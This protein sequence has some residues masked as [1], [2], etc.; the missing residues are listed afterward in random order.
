MPLGI[1]AEGTP[2][3]AGCPPVNL[4]T[5]VGIRTDLA[6]NGQA[7]SEGLNMNAL[8][9]RFPGTGHPGRPLAGGSSRPTGAAQAAEHLAGGQRP[10]AQIAVGQPAIDHQ[11]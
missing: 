1:T 2:A 4:W 10:T 8:L 9:D 5:Q 3:I 11:F 7:G 6:E